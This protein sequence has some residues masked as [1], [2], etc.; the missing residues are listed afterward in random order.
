LVAG[1]IDCPTPAVSIVLS[2]M[3]PDRVVG[4]KSAAGGTAAS[5]R[6]GGGGRRSVG[7]FPGPASARAGIDAGWVRG[8]AGGTVAAAMLD[9]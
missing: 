6:I 8:K 2:A 3:S 9:G 5:A 4:G 1:A 7:T